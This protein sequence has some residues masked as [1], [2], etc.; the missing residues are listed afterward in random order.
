[1]K[2]EEIRK[3]LSNYA[4]GGNSYLLF[5]YL[6]DKKH[7]EIEISQED[8]ARE[9]NKTRPSIKA[10]LELLSK[11]G[12]IEISYKKIKIVGENNEK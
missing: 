10:S 6:L 7:S 4:N 5:D 2:R 12:V 9:L 8:L 11:I 3:K 1:M